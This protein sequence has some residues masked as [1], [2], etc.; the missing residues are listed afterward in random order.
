M[1]YVGLPLAIEVAKAGLHVVGVDIE[2]TKVD[3]IMTGKS[4]VIDV[5]DEEVLSVLKQCRFVATDDFFK[6]C[7][8][9]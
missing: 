4:Y 3:K 8:Y 6:G 7:R 9:Y 5:K 2:A 1:G